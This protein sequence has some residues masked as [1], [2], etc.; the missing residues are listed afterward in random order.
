MMIY[1]TPRSC[2]KIIQRY[3]RVSFFPLPVS[4]WKIIS[5]DQYFPDFRN[6]LRSLKLFTRNFCKRYLIYTHKGFSG[7]LKIPLALNEC[8]SSN[9]YCSFWAYGRNSEATSDFVL[10]HLQLGM[11]ADIPV[12]IASQCFH[13]ESNVTKQHWESGKQEYLTET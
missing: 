13:H 11:I 3:F 9:C 2:Q 12:D 1:Q 8:D 4:L 6:L 5:F 10:L 7:Q